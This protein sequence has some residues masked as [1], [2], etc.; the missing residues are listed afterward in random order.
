MVDR[1]R[2]LKVEAPATG[3]TETDDFYTDLDPSEDY[4]DARGVTFQSSTSNDDSVRVARDA[5]DNMVF[6]DVANPA[7]STL[8]TLLAGGGMSESTHETLLQLIHFVD[9]GPADGFA[10]LATKTVTGGLFPTLTEWHRADD[11]LLISKAIDRSAGAATTLKPTP[12]VWTLYDTNGT[13][14][15]HT[16][17]DAI[18]YSGIAE[19][20]R[21]RTI[22]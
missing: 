14:V 13:T 3:G 18:T 12:I 15:L 7:D 19:A 8:T 22:T 9:E 11:T 20:S 6:R 5:S 10:S 16:V 21:V 2:P 1:V 17:S 4:V